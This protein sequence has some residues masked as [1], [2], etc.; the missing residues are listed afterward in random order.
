MYWREEVRGHGHV[1]S[2]VLEGGGEGAQSCEY[3]REEVRGCSHVLEGGGERV[4]SCE[5]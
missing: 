1:N 4:W 3:W 2:H 5:V